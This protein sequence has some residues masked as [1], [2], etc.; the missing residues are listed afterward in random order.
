MLIA[1][2]GRVDITNSVGDLCRESFTLNGLIVNGGCTYGINAF[3]RIRRVLLRAI[4]Q[5]SLQP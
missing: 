5:E 1:R 2:Y 4:R 3:H